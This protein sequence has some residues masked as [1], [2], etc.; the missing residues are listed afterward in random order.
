MPQEERQNGPQ[1][2]PTAPGGLHQGAKRRPKM[3]SGGA[4]QRFKIVQDC[5][6]GSPQMPQMGAKEWPE[7][8]SK[9]A[10]N[11]MQKGVQG[12]PHDGPTR[13]EEVA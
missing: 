1:K 6:E 10:S 4:A 13:L 3:V 8:V 7:E 9:R 2:R 12:K 5:V 11:R